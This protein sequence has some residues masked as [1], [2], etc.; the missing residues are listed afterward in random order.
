M[1]VASLFEPVQGYDRSRLIRLVEKLVRSCREDYARLEEYN[2][3]FSPS[4]ADEKDDDAAL[5]VLQSIQRLYDEWAAEAE[6]ILAR[7]DELRR[8]GH[9]IPEAA[10]LADDHAGARAR[11]S[12]KPE[13]TIIAMQQLRRGEGVPLEVVRDE[14]RRRRGA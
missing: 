3:E 4:L 13:R 9:A 5:G 1:S 11:L 8:S 6:V 12:V 2:R 14:L 10:E 7:V